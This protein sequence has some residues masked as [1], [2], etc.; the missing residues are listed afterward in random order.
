ME[1]RS[2]TKISVEHVMKSVLARGDEK[3]EDKEDD[4]AARQVI[5]TLRT[6]IAQ[7]FHIDDVACGKYGHL[8]SCQI[9][10]VFDISHFL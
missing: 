7:H 4:A 3:S 6:R 9:R 2:G 8:S 5:A 10:Q 1:Q